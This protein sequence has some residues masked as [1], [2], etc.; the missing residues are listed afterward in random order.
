MPI[1]GAIKGKKN[2]QFWLIFWML[3][4]HNWITVLVPCGWDE[5][6]SARMYDILAVDVAAAIDATKKTS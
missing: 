3:T 2:L 5:L 6:L 1:E 4:L